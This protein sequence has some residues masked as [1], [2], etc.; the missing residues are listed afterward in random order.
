MRLTPHLFDLWKKRT[1]IVECIKSTSPVLSSVTSLDQIKVAVV[2]AG[3]AFAVHTDTSPETGRN[4]SITIYLNSEDS[5]GVLRVYPF[6]HISQES[7][8]VDIKPVF[9]RMVL[10]S[11]CN[12]FHRVL[13]ADA[14][15][16]V[17]SDVGIKRVLNLRVRCY[18]Q[19]QV[20]LA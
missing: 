14:G 17:V 5:L 12:T 4:L 18:R 2:K 15:E 7:V 16:G 19:T 9:G 10:F 8:P 3:G 20:R 1:E 6:P 13:P 11:S